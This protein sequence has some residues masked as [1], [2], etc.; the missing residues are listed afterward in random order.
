M[1]M[2][3]RELFKRLA[4]ACA[5]AGITTIETIDPKPE[6]VIVLKHPAHTYLSEQAWIRLRDEMKRAFPGRKVLVIEEGWTIETLNAS[7][8]NGSVSINQARAALHLEPI[9][10]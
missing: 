4:G 6:E 2:G 3:R 10:G 5:A 8:Q 7:L 9:G 1:T